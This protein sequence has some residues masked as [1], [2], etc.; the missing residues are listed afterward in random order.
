MGLVGGQ[1]LD[2]ERRPPV[3]VD[4]DREVLRAPVGHETREHVEEAIDGVHR[5]AGRQGVEAAE[6]EARVVDEEQH[7]VTRPLSLWRSAHASRLGGT[8]AA[9]GPGRL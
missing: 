5:D 1:R 8:V 6:E 2:A 7:G 3:L 9:P 4:G